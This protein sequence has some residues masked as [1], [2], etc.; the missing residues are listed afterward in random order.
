MLWKRLTP[1][2]VV[3]AA[4]VA[5]WC[6]AG[7]TAAQD[8]PAEEKQEE[9]AAEPKAEEKPAE[10]KPAQEKPA[11]EKP[12]EETK[13]AEEKPAEESK[14]EGP[15]AVTLVTNLENPSGLA[16]HAKTGHVFIASKYGVYRYDP[17]GHGV[18]LEIS[19][20]PTDVYGKGPMY[21]IG[22]LGLDFLGEETLIVGDGSRPD[23]EELV[24]TYKISDAPA[25]MPV[26][27]GN[28]EKTLGPIK[29]GADTASEEKTTKP[30]GN[31]YDVAVGEKGVFISSNGDDTKGW[32]H[33]IEVVDGKLGDKLVPTIATKAD[34][35][36]DAPVPLEFSADKTELYVGQ[37]GEINVPNDSLLLVYDPNSGEL[38]K[39]YPLGLHD[40]AGMAVSPKTKKIY[41]TDFAWAKPEEAG[42]F[43]VTLEGDKA[44]TKKILQLDK[45]TA[46]AFDKDGK[47]YVTTIGTVDEKA[48]TKDGEQLSPGKLMVIDAGL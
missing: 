1:S 13:P 44:T 34:V 30:E 20:Y 31:F 40:P 10:E 41:V 47:L 14:A 25:D 17:K 26:P 21:D 27:E 12:A 2:F 28:A 15:E 46:L 48:K 7:V 37:M 45:P 43:E 33:K 39:Q 11:E 6:T 29:E 8:K 32:I 42:L 19:G 9:K 36:V 22:P 5:V 35:Q 23:G 16:V 24:R 18:T 3:A 38:K 4:A